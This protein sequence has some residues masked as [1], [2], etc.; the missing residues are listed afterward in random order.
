MLNMNAN[1]LTLQQLSSVSFVH[2]YWFVVKH[3]NISTKSNQ[4]TAPKV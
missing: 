4:Q 2:I 1:A 3:A